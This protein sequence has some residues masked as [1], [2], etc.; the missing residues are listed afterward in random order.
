[1]RNESPIDPLC[2]VTN[3]G[4][5]RVSPSVAPP[6]IA[7]IGDAFFVVWVTAPAEPAPPVP[8]EVHAAIVDPNGSVVVTALVATGLTGVWR[9]AVVQ[10]HGT[11]VV[12][13]IASADGQSGQVQAVTVGADGNP[14][15]QVTRLADDARGVPPGVMRGRESRAARR[16]ARP[17]GAPPLRKG[18]LLVLGGGGAPPARGNVN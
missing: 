7:A 12:A 11:M 15:S 1:A 16:A 18:G 3:L 14:R 2:N 9:P 6:A 5:F 17:H 10:T 13:W 4:C 8:T